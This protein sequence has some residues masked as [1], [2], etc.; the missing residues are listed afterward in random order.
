[1]FAGITSIERLL[2]GSFEGH[3][4]AWKIFVEEDLPDIDGDDKFWLKRA[5]AIELDMS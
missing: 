5:F 3:R 2:N 1:V 4:H